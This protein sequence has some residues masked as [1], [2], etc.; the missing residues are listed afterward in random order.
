MDTVEGT[1]TVGTAVKGVSVLAKGG[2]AT[3]TVRW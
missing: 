3:G 1:L 2:K